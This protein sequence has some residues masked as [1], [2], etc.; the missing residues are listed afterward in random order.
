VRAVKNVPSGP[1]SEGLITKGDAVKAL[2]EP[3]DA[4]EPITIVERPAF[5]KLPIEER[6][7]IMARQAREMAAHYRE[8]KVEDLETG[9]IV[10]Y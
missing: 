6:R 4:Q 8:K 2:G 1:M 7:K 9:E 10:E 3:V 5:L